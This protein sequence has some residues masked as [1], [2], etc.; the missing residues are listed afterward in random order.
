VTG[1]INSSAEAYSEPAH[2]ESPAAIQASI[3]IPA[4]NASR[5]LPVTLRALQRLPCDWEVIVVDDHSTDDTLGL[6]E[7]LGAKALISH[8]HSSDYAARNTGA[9]KARGEWLIFID[10][11]IEVDSEILVAAVERMAGSNAA[12][13]FGLYDTGRHLPNTVS[14]YKNYWIHYTTRYAPRPFDWLNTSMAIIRR[15]SFFRLGGFRERFSRHHGGGDLDFGRRVA[16]ELGPV[17]LDLHANIRHHKAFTLWS[18]IKNDFRRTRGWL[19]SAVWTRGALDTARQSGL[20]NVSRR[21]SYGALAAT[22]GLGLGLVS[23]W[24]PSVVWGSAL[25][26]TTQQLLNLDFSVA[27]VRAKVRGAIWF[28]AL[29]VIDGAACGAGLIYELVRLPFYRIDFPNNDASS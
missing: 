12:A 19:R 20:A 7:A 10:S 14:R 18:L 29:L 22:A 26:L 15:D 16:R 1:A 25:L 21:F 17:E 23:P 6:A 28:P 13:V 24:W 5:T 8:G 9:R 27:A 2:S 3:I 11:D 4:R